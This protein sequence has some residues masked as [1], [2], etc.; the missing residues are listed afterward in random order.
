[1]VVT[2]SL[3]MPDM[4]T[5]QFFVAE[6]NHE[7]AGAFM[8][9]RNEIP[10]S[11]PSKSN[12]IVHN[13]ISPATIEVVPSP[14]NPELIAK[15]EK[16][17]SKSIESPADLAFELIQEEFA[18]EASEFTIQEAKAA[19]ARIGVNHVEIPLPPAP[20][21]EELV[22]P[23]P[24]L[25]PVDAVKVIRVTSPD[26]VWES[27]SFMKPE[28]ESNPFYILTIESSTESS[29]L[30]DWALITAQVCP[31]EESWLIPDDPFAKTS[32]KTNSDKTV[33]VSTESEWLAILSSDD[34]PISM[35]EPNHHDELTDR[36]TTPENAPKAVIKNAIRLT[37][38]A[39]AAWSQLVA[40]AY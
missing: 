25:A 33:E 8:T 14:A 7:I 16:I 31:L 23:D 28:F 6:I 18:R 26:G 27:L 19:L 5:C 22:F 40:K 1:M 34:A 37:A 9:L 36:T 4:G 12:E 15:P 32:V 29:S 2:L 13:E 35:V 21:A 10:V 30:G 38:E 11:A 39:I 3:P 24:G 20:A 17:E